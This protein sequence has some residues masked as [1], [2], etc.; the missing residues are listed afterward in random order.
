MVFFVEYCL[1]AVSIAAAYFS[2]NLGARWFR[3]A[4]RVLSCL[5]RRRGLAVL[6]V[7]LLALAV[8]AALLPVLPVPQPGIHDDFGYL[9][10][11]DTFA[12]GRVANPTHP[13]WTH[14]ESFHINHRPTYV[15]MFY[16]AQGLV[17]A[18]GQV[19]GMHPFVGVWLC[20]GGMGAA[21]CWML[22]GW[23]PS[24]WALLGGLLAIIRLGSFSYWAN[25]YS[26]GALPA[27]GGA[28]VLG[29]LPRLKRRRRVRYALVMGAG[30]A[31]LANTRP[32]ESLFFCLPVGV[33]LFAW[34]LGAKGPP[35]RLSLL[36][37]VLP[38]GL[39]LAAVAGGMAYYFWRTTGSPFRTP[40][41]VNVESYMIVPYFPWQPLRPL[42]HY[43]HPVMA[44]FY[45][46]DWQMQD[47]QLARSAPIQVLGTKALD[48][49]RF[50]LGPVL[51][52]PLLAGIGLRSPFRRLF[53][54][55]TGFLWLVCCVYFLGLALPI[56][57]IPHYAAPL[58][59][60]LYALVLQGLRRLRQW[61]WRGEPV[62]LAAARSVPAICVLM[63]LVRAAAPS[64]H[65][66]L[67]VE[68]SHTWG[69]VHFEN[70]DRAE[71]LAKIAGQPGDHLVIV[72]YEPGHLSANEWVYNQADIDR[73]RVIWARDMGSAANEELIR[74]FPQ[75]HVW[76]AGADLGPPRLLPY[77]GL[78]DRQSSSPSRGAP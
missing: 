15:A 57:F 77:P 62:G 58:T 73:A 38:L 11:G 70:L 12:H 28:L 68:W 72:R 14:F 22:Q 55:K 24:R 37:I 43:R 17:L 16:P 4:G 63:L 26:G 61:R 25:S 10:M 3:G 52:L 60:A 29:S 30:L 33:A 46:Q 7:G 35:L 8:R 13:M 21:I 42:P 50:Y 32:Y 34:M 56:Y 54:G 78:V 71:A 48:L 40:Y 36:R 59:G 74:Y 44:K 6:G 64:L 45:L 5:G 47:Y 18:L 65:L 67:P 49:W 1:V 31:I 66:P 20:A 76:L 9:L 69:S 27:M 51:T 2:P 75:R 23:L 39:L 53:A 19:I 41:L